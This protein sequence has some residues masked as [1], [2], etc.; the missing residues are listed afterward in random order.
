M[1]AEGARH[2]EMQSSQL[3]DGARQSHVKK[4]EIELETLRPMLIRDLVSYRLRWETDSVQPSVP[5][6]AHVWM[7]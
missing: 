1:T 3:G 5:S 2:P 6:T 4:T 7:G